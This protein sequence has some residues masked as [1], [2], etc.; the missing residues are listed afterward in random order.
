LTEVF[1][2]QAKAKSIRITLTAQSEGSYWSVHELD[3][4]ADPKPA[5]RSQAIATR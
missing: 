1:F 2:S 3:V 4:I 5:S